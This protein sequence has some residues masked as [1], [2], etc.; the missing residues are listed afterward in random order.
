MEK[1]TGKE[2]QSASLNF[3]Y[4]NLGSYLHSE[5]RFRCKMQRNCNHLTMPFPTWSDIIITVTYS[6]Y[7]FLVLGV[8]KFHVSLLRYN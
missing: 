5:L 7:R 4:P 6:A 8:L 1:I 2:K 3:D